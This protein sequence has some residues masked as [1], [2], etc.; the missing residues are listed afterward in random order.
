[1]PQSTLTTSSP[2]SLKNNLQPPYK[3]QSFFSLLFVQLQS[4]IQIPYIK[5]SFWLFLVTQ[6]LQNTPLQRVSDLQ[7]QIVYSSLTTEFIYYLLVISTHAFF[8]IIMITS[9]LDILV[10]TKYQNYFTMNIPG[11]A[12]MLMYNNSASPMSLVY[13]PSHNITSPT[14]FSNN[15]LFLNNHGIPFLQTSLRNSHHPPSLTLYWSQ[16]TGSLSRQSLF[17]PITTLCLWTQHICLSFMCFPNTAFLSMSPLTEAWSL[18]Q[19]S[20]DLQVLLSTYGFISLQ[21]ITPKVMNKPNTQIRSSSNISMYI[22]TTSKI[23]GPNSYVMERLNTN[24]F[25][26]LFFYFSFYIDFILFFFLFFFWI[27]KRHMTSHMI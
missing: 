21:A 2:S 26:F 4:W 16:L 5:T 17:L 20:S 14:D 27:M 19:T 22:V 18:C 11:L 7:T 23:T 12:F 3:L 13:N 15:S 9:L 8:S 25:I 1:M 24:N 6:L 10:K